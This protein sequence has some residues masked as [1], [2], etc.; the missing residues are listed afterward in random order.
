MPVFLDRLKVQLAVS[1]GWTI[2]GKLP[3]AIRAF[4]ATE[5]D[6]VWHLHRGMKRLT[7][8]KIKAIMFAH[9]L[10]EESHA[11]EFAITYNQY[12]DRVM[13]P[14]AYERADLYDDY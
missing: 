8:P 12:A 10:E 14:A 13:T 7:D 11:E 9:S 5:A 1:V 4:Q 2:K 3:E 6:G